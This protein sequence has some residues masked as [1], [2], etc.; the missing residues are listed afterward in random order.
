MAGYDWVSHLPLGMLGLWTAPKDDSNF[1]LAEA[2]YGANLFL[3]GEFIVHSEF[4][5]KVF[6]RKVERAVTGF[7][8]PPRHH[9][10]A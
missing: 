9:F 7:S 10:A 4:P 2:V 1:S 3:P 8:G 6:L 5:S